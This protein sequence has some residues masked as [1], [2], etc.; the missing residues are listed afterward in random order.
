MNREFLNIYY[1]YQQTILIVHILFSF[2]AVFDLTI[3]LTF[4]TKLSNPNSRI[5]CLSSPDNN[6]LSV[7]NPKKIEIY[8]S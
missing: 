6:I 5:R 1:C 4:W 8:T 3:I 7:A 2:L